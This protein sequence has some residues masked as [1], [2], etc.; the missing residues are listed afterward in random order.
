MIG[1]VSRSVGVLWS[2]FAKQI[3]HHSGLFL[4]WSRARLLKNSLYTTM[5]DEQRKICLV[6]S[7][8]WGSAIAKVAGENTLLK[9]DKFS[10]PVTMYVYEEMVNGRKLSEIINTDHENPKY[11]PG[12]KLPENVVAIPDLVE[13][14]KE[15]DILVFVLP[16]NFIRGVCRKLR[17]NIKEEA[18]G[19][20]LIKGLDSASE[21]ISLIS[22]LIE[23]ELSIPCHVLMGANLAGEVA[24]E[25]FVEATIGCRITEH[26]SI[27]KDVFHS[28]Y[29]KINTVA[30]SV[31]VE[32]CGA[33]KNAVALG[34][35][36]ADALAC[37]ANTKAAIIRLGIVEI[38]SFAEKFY[39]GVK[40]E[41]F[42]ESCGVG[43]LIASCYGGRNRKCA[44]LFVRTG[45][46]FDDI[47]K[48]YLNGQKLQGPHTLQE[49]YKILKKHELTDSFPL[50]TAISKVVYE[51]YPPSTLIEMLKDHF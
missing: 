3:P 50:F 5:S 45:K 7:G 48:E 42:F 26:A 18:I 30:D 8:N 39:E 1:Q 34:A 9:P 36:I 2:S 35:G 37:G 15:A 28:K 17:G 21:G 14:A 47:E 49:L 13:A 29:F 33:L 46:N 22:R 25:M 10:S 43:D 24:K 20:S 41:T 4:P 23:E 38:L 16:H 32:L 11:M 6:G 44:E 12:V 51:N 19:I 31:S 27:L 40:K